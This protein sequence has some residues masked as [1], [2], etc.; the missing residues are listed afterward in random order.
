MMQTD[1]TLIQVT[2][3]HKRPHG[4]EMD[5]FFFFFEGNECLLNK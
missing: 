2:C 3:C 5:F 4:D 1:Y